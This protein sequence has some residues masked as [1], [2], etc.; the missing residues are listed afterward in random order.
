MNLDE[1]LALQGLTVSALQELSYKTNLG[2]SLHGRLRQYDK[3][4]LLNEI[5]T[6]ADFLEIEAQKYSFAID[7]RIKSRESIASKYER[8]EQNEEVGKV[9]ND[10]LGFRILCDSYDFVL[11]SV[12][13]NFRV[14]NMSKGKAH[15]D[16]YR[17]VH[18][19]YQLDNLHYPVEIQF[20]T[21]YDR[22]LNDW[23]HDY[24][25]KYNYPNIIGQT[26]RKS[27][28]NGQIKNKQEFEVIFDGL[29]DSQG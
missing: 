24:I 12:P 3:E 18:V 7:Y 27:Y 28:E 22:Q 2:R 21:Y 11:D 15:D 13:E 20:N 23:L 17:G 26:L 16:G 29:R 6:A 8:H 10:L 25:Y 19:Y 9:F 4:K 14:V 1:Y 5:Y